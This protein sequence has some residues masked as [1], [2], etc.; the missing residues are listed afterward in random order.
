MNLI[1]EVTD[2]NFKTE[3]LESNVPVVVDFWA[4]WCGPCRMVSPVLEEVAQDMGEKIKFVKLN[5]DEN[6]Q[7]AS[8]Y[9]IMAI[10]SLLVFKQGQEADR[11]V[12]FKPKDQLLEQFSGHVDK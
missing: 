6:Q 9:R 3:V 12:G 10:P 8:Q 7:V 1:K 2:D 5:T 11:V 4:P